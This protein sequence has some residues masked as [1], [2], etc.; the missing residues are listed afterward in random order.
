MQEVL[1]SVLLLHEG[2]M[3]G[4]TIRIDRRYRNHQP[5]RCLPTEIRQVLANL[6]GTV[7]DAMTHNTDECVLTLRIQR[8]THGGNGASGVRIDISDTGTGIPAAAR[9][10]IF[11]P[12]FTTKEATGTGLGLWISR[13]I[14]R[15]H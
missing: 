11:E 15:R 6:V 1:E 3:L 8:S 4:S 13:E 10:K 9:T 14:V 12:F 7:I 5:I 2:R